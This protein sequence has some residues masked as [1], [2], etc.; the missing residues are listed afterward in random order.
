[1]A[2]AEGMDGSLCVSCFGKYRDNGGSREAWFSAVPSV[3]R[4]DVIVKGE[5]MK[6]IFKGLLVSAMAVVMTASMAMA[7]E[8]SVVT[9]QVDSNLT[10]IQEAPADESVQEAPVEESIQEEQTT[11]AVG[12]TNPLTGED[13]YSDEAVNHRPVA[14]MINN[15]PDSYPQYNIG[16]ADVI[17]EF[18]VEH[19]L[20]RFLAVFADYAN[21]PYLV[22]VRS[23]RYYF[24]AVSSGFDAIYVHWGADNTKM[25]YYNSL[26]LDSYDGMSNTYLFGRDQERLD[27]GYALEHTSCLYG[28]L[29]PDQL[30]A[31]G[32][33]T[34]LKDEYLGEAFNFVP[35]GT[36]RVPEE[37]TVNFANI[38]Y[39]QQSTQFTY[40]ESTGL[41][42]KFANDN[43][44][45]DG[46]SG[47]Q[48]TFE[49]VLILYTEISAR[50]DYPE[51]D[52]KN[53]DVFGG[54]DKDYAV[55]YYLTEG[56]AEQIRWA[57]ADES[58]RLKFYDMDGNEITINR[59]KSYITY[60]YAD[61]AEL[62]DTIP[63]AYIQ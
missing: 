34:T 25:D 27:A 8:L 4:M 40:N 22:S 39:G 52:R 51:A 56:H 57:K 20:T 9:S 53:L 42:E 37:M 32:K 14:V 63:E 15:H 5:K 6:K 30:A 19:N 47:E 7:G 33:R 55:G 62:S 28:Y 13:G 2:G 54:L 61:S 1:M 35:F 17:F 16:Q 29:L 3:N 59:G 44:Q 43:P 11:E 49:N 46:I 50:D 23:Y 41:Y 38:E 18:V 26:N 21:V 58:S 48:L 36:V 12:N 24:P 45:I 10:E 60:T 31:D